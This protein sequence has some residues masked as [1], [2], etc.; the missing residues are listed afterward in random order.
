MKNNI[1]KKSKGKLQLSQG[2]LISSFISAYFLSAVIRMI[3]NSKKD[4]SFT[5]LEFLQSSSILGHLFLIVCIMGALLLLEYF[6]P[7]A[8]FTPHT[9]L[10]S[11][12]LMSALLL[13]NITT[14]QM[15]IYLGVMVVMAIVILY[16]T[17]Q[18]CF[19]FIKSDAK[20]YMLWISVAAL[21]LIFGYFIGAIGVFRQL[22]YSTPNFDFGIFCNMYHNM[23]E[24][25]LPNVTC[26]R[27]QLL[28][29][30]AVHFSPIFYVFLPIYAIFPYAITLQIL[31]TVTL[32]SG[33]IPL[34]LIAKKKGLSNNTAIVLSA[35]YAAF[36]AL[37][38]GTFYDL[39]ENC[40]LV[41]LLLWVFFF[42]E[43]KSYIPMAIFGILTLMVKEDAFVYLCI[44]ALYVLISDKKWKISLPILAVAIIYFL[45][46]S[47]IMKSHGMGIMSNRYDN[48]IYNEEDGLIGAIKTIILNPT[49]VISQIF[50]TSKDGFDKIWY[51]LQLFLPL[52]FLPFATKKISRY[53]LIVPILLN[54]LTMYTYQPNITFQY[55]FGVMAFLFYATVL[56]ISELVGFSK[57]Y[58]LTLAVVG[59]VL[60][61]FV[62]CIP[63]YQIYE[64]RYE[65]NSDSY[66]RF[67]YALTE[68]L[69]EDASVAASSFLITHIYDRDEI[70]EV[71]YHKEN[72]KYKTDI[73]YVVLDMRY[74]DES[75]DAAGFYLSHG[76]EEYYLDK[77]H[78]WILKK[79]S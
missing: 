26:E 66:E 49:Y 45:T 39:H 46:V 74:K 47:S 72:G 10:V 27:D 5:S 57:K 58:L 37:G 63:K 64:E 14:S 29:H 31:Q 15:Y 34:I 61:F 56:N 44:F 22:T 50:V 23:T 77:G 25:G 35:I 11:T 68:V 18:G 79:I 24:S 41:P 3:V 36:P 70:Y 7:K 43:K 51:V 16:T 54:L 21:A 17:K 19:H 32:Y 59:S 13:L 75:N 73:D 78:V 53:V 30:F 1:Q 9:L 2:L 60:M 38:T 76:Y 40:F 65:Y 69:P 8:K 62:L 52:A 12:V 71:K 42:Y 33:I 48:L 6:Y 20:P 67:E 4:V 28:S 55:S